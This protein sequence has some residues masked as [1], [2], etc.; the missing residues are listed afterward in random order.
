MLGFE[1]V[2]AEALVDTLVA[3]KAV[4]LVVKLKVKT[5]KNLYYKLEVKLFTGM[6]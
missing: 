5:T 1:E 6:G 4:M 3:G 2:L